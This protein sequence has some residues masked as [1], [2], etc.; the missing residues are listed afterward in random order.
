MEIYESENLLTRAAGLAQLWE[1]ALH[2]LRPLP[3]VID[4]RNLGLMGAVELSP[5]PND[6]GSRGYEVFR[7]C[8]ENGVLVRVTADT[9]ALSPPLTLEP[10]H[11]DTIRGVLSEALTRVA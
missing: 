8:F 11:I 10:S 1:D 9:I 6:P 3:N 2:S 7:Y 4:I 5:R